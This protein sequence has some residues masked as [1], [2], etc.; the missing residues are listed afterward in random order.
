MEKLETIKVATK[1]E[2]KDVAGMIANLIKDEKMIGIQAI[3]AGAVNQAIKSIII[4][5]GYVAPSGYNLG[6][7]PAFCDVEVDGEQRTG[8]KLIV[9]LR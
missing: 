4:A 9:T 6:C 7:I 1:S 5:R 3:G 8:I 2:P